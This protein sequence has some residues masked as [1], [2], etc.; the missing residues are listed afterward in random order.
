MVDQADRTPSRRGAEPERCPCDR[1]DDAAAYVR[2]LF[3]RIGEFFDP[4]P[5]VE[6]NLIVVF[7]DPPRC[8]ARCLELLGIGNMET[9]DERGSARYVVIYEVDAVRRFLAVVRPSI[10]DVEPLARKI[11]GYR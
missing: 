6:R 7:R 2:G 9:S 3:E 10:P 8:L 4:D 5:H 1:H 11:A